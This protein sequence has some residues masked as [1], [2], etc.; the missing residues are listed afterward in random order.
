VPCSLPA[1]RKLASSEHEYSYEFPKVHVPKFDVHVPKI[2]VPDVHVPKI[3][4]PDVHV[5]KIKIPDVHMPKIKVPTV[6][7]PKTEVH[8][9]PHG[10]QRGAASDLS[11][12]CLCS[13]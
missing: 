2:K 3:K 6:H 8:H 11:C 7:A 4:I 1:G 13:L 5:P 12:V 9:D 10:E